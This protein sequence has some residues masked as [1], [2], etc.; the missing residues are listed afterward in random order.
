MG[1]GLFDSAE[2][3]SYLIK[4]DSNNKIR[5][6]ILQRIQEKED[7]FVIKR[8]TFQYG[9]KQTNQ[10]DIVVTE[11]KAKRDASAQAILQYNAKLKEY[12]DKGY[13]EI[14]KHPED[15]SLTELDS[16]LPKVSTDANGFAKH[17]LAKS[18][19]KVK[20]TSI[21]KVKYWYASRK[22]DGKL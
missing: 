1:L 14:E 8:T 20:Q 2:E 21:D 15:Y 12:K 19:D 3:I 7:Y 6:V 17:M 11:G 16:I 22:I 18:S 5:C 10:P 9:G 4:K 13:K